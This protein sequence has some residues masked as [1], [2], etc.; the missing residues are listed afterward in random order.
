MSSIRRGETLLRFAERT[1]DRATV[2]HVIAPALADLQ[3]ECA[4]AGISTSR[5]TTWVRAYWG[6]LK[7]IA[8]CLL[9]DVAVDRDLT[10]IRIAGQMAAYV[11]VL[12]LLM[13]I[14]SVK[15]TIDF[16][17]KTS[18]KAAFD[19]GL[20]ML[21]SMILLALPSALLF[22]IAFQRDRADT[23]RPSLLPKVVAITGLSTLAV[24]A[25][26]M[27]GAPEANQSY[28][29]LVVDAL[30]K[31]RGEDPPL[32]RRGL[33]EMTLP[34]LNDHLRHAPSV[35]E[36]LRG[37]NHRLQRFAFVALVPITALLAF[38][39]VD[40][41]RS[42]LATLGAALA[43]LLAYSICFSIGANRYGD[44]SMYGAWT[45]NGIFFVLAVRLMRTRRPVQH[46]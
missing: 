33:N 40:R 25:L 26:L 43:I 44:P 46:V 6:V 31:V 24:F 3:H 2:E 14:P 15:W 35:A 5:V 20:L 10:V 22:A 42:R 38:S 11:I 27:F 36:Q 12:I 39:L 21:P 34:M 37:R 30:S 32:L 23:A 19:A 18:S 1:F 9:R 45:A 17:T 7:T 29:M 4:G 8:W 41:W 28:R 16:A 13:S